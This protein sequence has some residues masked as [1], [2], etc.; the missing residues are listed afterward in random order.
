MGRNYDD[1][2]NVQ[3]RGDK[4]EKQHRIVSDSFKVRIKV[5]QGS[6]LSTLLLIT[7]LNDLLKG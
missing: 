6:A 1:Q 3:R 5:L 2:G 7:L 4:S